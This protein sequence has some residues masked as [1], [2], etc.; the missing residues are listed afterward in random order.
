M[1]TNARRFSPSRST[2][3]KASWIWLTAAGFFTTFR[4]QNALYWSLRLSWNI[5]RWF[6]LIQVIGQ[7]VLAVALS[8]WVTAF[9]AERYYVKLIA[10][11]AILALC[12]VVLLIAA[13]FRK[14]PAYTE[15]NGRLLKKETAPALWQRIS[16]MAQKLGIAPPDNFFVGIDD[17][18]FVTE[19]PVKVGETRYEG[20]TLFASLSL[21]KALSRSEA[22][23]V[24]AHELGHFSGEDTLY[25]RRTSPLLGKYI[26]YL[27]ALY[28]GVISRPVFY[29]MFFFWNLYQISLNKL[30]RER[31]FRADTSSDAAVTRP[32]HQRSEVS[33]ESLF[34]DF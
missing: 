26:H 14:L 33:R 21:L 1:E 4:S 31:E 18:F 3:P 30:R 9:W 32:A 16:Q 7:G 23:A 12:A 22:D 20:R 24:L 28:K 2:S 34:S 13:I 11:A 29:F 8:F 6:A 10:V 17:N 25:S 19:H 5:L 27:D 15:F